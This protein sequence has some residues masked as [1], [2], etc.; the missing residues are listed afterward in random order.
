MK[1]GKGKRKRKKPLFC[2]M[3]AGFPCLSCGVFVGD[4]W[5]SLHSTVDFARP[6]QG[7]QKGAI[8]CGYVVELWRHGSLSH[9]AFVGQRVSLGSSYTMR[10]KYVTFV[11][12]CNCTSMIYGKS[13]SFSYSQVVNTS[14]VR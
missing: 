7:R 12:F 8:C 6:A 3:L 11:H 13:E 2:V 9:S 1:K 4:L 10:R 14:S 5:A